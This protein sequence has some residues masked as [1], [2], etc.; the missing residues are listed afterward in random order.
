MSVQNRPLA[1][2]A[3][4]TYNQEKFAEAAVLGV[5]RQTYE[6]LEIII[7]DNCST[8]GTFD[9]IQETVARHS[10]G[11]NVVIVR[12]PRNYGCVGN[13]DRSFRLA[14][15]AFVVVAHGDDISRPGRV[16]RIR[17]EWSESG[18][19]GFFSNAR[20]INNEGVA[21]G[22]LYNDERPAPPASLNLDNLLSAGRGFLVGAMEA[23]DRRVFEA[24]P[25]LDDALESE[26]A[27]YA[28]RACLIGGRVGLRYIDEA[29]VDYRQHD[30]NIGGVFPKK[31]REA[32][33]AAWRGVRRRRADDLTQWERD[34]LS[35]F[36]NDT[37]RL[38]R[39]RQLV[40]KTVAERDAGLSR[41]WAEC[42]ARS[43]KGWFSGLTA[44]ECYRLLREFHWRRKYG[45]Q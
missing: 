14:K 24:F 39:A 42:L 16:E 1:S 8:D 34:L 7:S 32:Q 22:L 44:R 10:N 28:F 40:R 33:F 17:R 23:F 2:I 13:L 19:L 20:I 29:L 18:A 15:G 11:R 37:K 38:K 26:D 25:P 43:A 45:L 31:T 35:K 21:G 36:P 4:T 27:I 41:T 9:I 30:D 3:L 12:Q 5:L 6:P